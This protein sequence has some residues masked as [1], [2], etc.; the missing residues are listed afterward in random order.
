V[1]VITGT[2]PPNGFILDYTGNAT[3]LGKFLRR[4]WVFPGPGGTI[5]GR[6]LFV[7]AN[8]D[9]LRVTFTGRF[10]TPTEGTGDYV[11]AGGTG[12]FS[13]ATGKAKAL[14]SARDGKFFVSFDGKISY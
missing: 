8:K 6:I 11:I 3:H 12:R 5:S 7:A 4:E 14:V 2:T 10:T 1:G 13:H 9:E